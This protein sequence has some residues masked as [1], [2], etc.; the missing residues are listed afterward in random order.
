MEEA[1]SDLE[2]SEFPGVISNIPVA[3][4]IV[5]EISISNLSAGFSSTE[6]GTPHT[7]RVSVALDLPEVEKREV[8]VLKEF[9]KN[10]RSIEHH[11]AFA[12]KTLTEGSQLVEVEQRTL[13][14]L[15]FDDVRKPSGNDRLLEHL[16]DERAQMQEGFKLDAQMVSGAV[17]V[18]TGLSIGYVIWL[19]RGGVLLGSVLSSLPAWR[20]ID[21][22][23]VLSSLGGDSD[24]DDDDSLEDLVERSEVNRQAETDREN[25]GSQAGRH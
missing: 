13:A 22:L 3:E 1:Y 5:E 24:N 12:V 10:P 19:V 23:P 4:A 2:L 11:R 14:D 6:P 21:P 8:P 15:F 16:D 9:I 18:S 7:P 25:D 20:N 17:S